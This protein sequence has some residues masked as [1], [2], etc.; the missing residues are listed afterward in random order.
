MPVLNKFRIKTPLDEFE[1]FLGEEMNTF[2]GFFLDETEK[3][4][5]V[6]E[7]SEVPKQ[8]EVEVKDVPQNRWNNYF[9]RIFKFSSD[10]FF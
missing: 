8:E 9:R 7:A 10:L 6:A 4:Q 5:P 1:N 2:A 3:E